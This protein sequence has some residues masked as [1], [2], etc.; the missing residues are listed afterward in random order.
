MD[1]CV[2]IPARYAASR[3]PGKV[4]LDIHGKTML[5]HVYEKA[6]ESG[7]N[8]VVIATDDD[9]I[10]KVAQSFNAT[11]MMTDSEHQTGTDRIAEVA[12][13]C[14]WGCWDMLRHVG[15]GV[16]GLCSELRWHSQLWGCWD[17]A[18]KLFFVLLATR[19]SLCMLVRGL[20]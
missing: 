6:I 3:L 13:V 11:V 14:G 2:V 9:R 7:A 15:M 5:Q 20:V 16:E 4:L 19:G 1:F 8:E 18:P 17:D 12:S 10:Q